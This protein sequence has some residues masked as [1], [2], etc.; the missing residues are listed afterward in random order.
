MKNFLLLMILIFISFNT[1]ANIRTLEIG[2][3]YYQCKPYQNNKFNFENLTKSDQGRHPD[4]NFFKMNLGCHPD[5]EFTRIDQGRC[6]SP[7]SKAD[8]KTPKPSSTAQLSSNKWAP[9][10]WPI[11]RCFPT[12]R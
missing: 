9:R 12:S 7:N 11:C 6:W 1:K 8:P 2:S 4:K 5:P 10:L 3:L